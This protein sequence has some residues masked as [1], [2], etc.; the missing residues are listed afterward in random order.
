MQIQHHQSDAALITLFREGDGRA[1]ETLILRHKDK[2]YTAIYLLVRDRNLAEDIFQDCFLKVIRSMKEMD[3][4]YA[5]QGRF[6]PWVLRVA[7]NLCIDHFRRVKVR[8]P[9]TLSDGSDL[10]DMLWAGPETAATGMEQRETC[11]QVRAVIERL[12]EEQREVV[13]LRVYGELSFKEI[14]DITGVSINT[15]LGRMRYALLNMR[16]MLGKQELALRY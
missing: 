5:E 7:R 3:E 16:R 8:M 10:E 11:R 12:P 4:N 1:M 2:V 15:A 9:V 14:A 13:N 6:L